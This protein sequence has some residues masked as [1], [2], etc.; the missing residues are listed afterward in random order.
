VFFANG[1]WTFSLQ[2]T[3]IRLFPGQ[4]WVDAGITIGGLVL[5]AA[6]ITLILTW[7]TRKRR[8]LPPRKAAAKAQAAL[9][10]QDDATEAADPAAP[11]G[12]R[13]R[14]RNGSAE[15]RRGAGANQAPS[16]GGADAADGEDST[17]ER[18]GTAQE[19]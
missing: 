19:R 17:G 10:A 2:D 9:N 3:L 11:K 13:F 1:T 6:I 12:R 18:A 16:D 15:A 4:F 5:L 7:P 14:R 8:G